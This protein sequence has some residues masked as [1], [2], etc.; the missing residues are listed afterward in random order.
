MNTAPSSPQPRQPLPLVEEAPAVYQFRVW[1]RE[2]SPLIWRR[3]LI[4]EDSTLADLHDTLQIAFGWSDTHLHRFVHRCRDYGIH[5]AGGPWVTADARTVRLADLHLRPRER[6]T[7]T[8]DFGDG[9]VHEIRLEQQVPVDPRRTYPVCIG[10]AHGG[11]PEDCGGPWAF[12]AQR[13][14]YT[15][16]FIAE[17]VSAMLREGAIDDY[18][19]EI[20]EMCRWLECERLDRRAVNRRLRVYASG[21]EWWAEL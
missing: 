15:P 8:Y 10:G 9:W 12:M 18:R 6:F 4:R 13:Q 1:L 14:Q 2:I 19:E 5:S 3:L 21:G 17:Q 7:Y 16:F 20:G 11:P